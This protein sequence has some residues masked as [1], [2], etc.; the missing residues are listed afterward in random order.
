MIINIIQT[1]TTVMDEDRNVLS[2]RSL[3]RYVIIPDSG[4]V[5]KDIKTGQ[6]IHGN[7]YLSQKSKIKN[8]IEIDDPVVLEE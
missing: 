8:Y 5:L 1:V 6:V 4:K 2:T 7:V 3:E